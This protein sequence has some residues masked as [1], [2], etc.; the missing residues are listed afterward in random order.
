MRSKH[1]AETCGPGPSLITEALAAALHQAGAW[2]AIQLDINKSWTRFD[3]FLTSKG[4]LHAEPV[5]PA[6]I[7]DD[8]LLQPYSRDFLYL[9]ATGAA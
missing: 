9:T 4:K 5:L 6:I 7:Q 1:R 2:N 8:R 3:R